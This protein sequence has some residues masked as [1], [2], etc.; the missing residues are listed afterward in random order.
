MQANDRPAQEELADALAICNLDHLQQCI[1]A[2]ESIPGTSHKLLHLCVGPGPGAS[3]LASTS[4][5]TSTSCFDEKHV[6]VA[7]EYVL[8]KLAERAAATNLTWLEKIVNLS[9][10]EPAYKAAAGAFFE[11]YSHRKL[12]RG[13]TF[14]VRHVLPLESV[15]PLCP[16]PVQS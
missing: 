11:S 13:G 15:P 16:E 6:V 8:E 14:E 12:Q 3:D 1:G 9:M 7:S 10:S 2:P 4:T 5:S